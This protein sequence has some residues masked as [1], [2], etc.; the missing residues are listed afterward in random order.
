MALQNLI[1]NRPCNESRLVADAGL[2][3]PAS[4]VSQSRP[5]G[6]AAVILARHARQCA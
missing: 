1:T 3:V 6:K 4:A 2:K 5:M